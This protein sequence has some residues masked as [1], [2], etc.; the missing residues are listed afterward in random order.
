MDAQNISTELYNLSK[1]LEVLRTTLSDVIRLIVN[2]NN[3]INEGFNEIN[4]RL[5]A[6]E[7]KQGMQGVNTQLNEIKIELHKIQRAY[8]YEEIYSNLKSISGE[9]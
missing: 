8:P 1:E 2:L 4:N 7:G 3:A 9:A 6:L 5:S